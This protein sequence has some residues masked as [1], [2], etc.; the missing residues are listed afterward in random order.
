MVLQEELLVELQ[1][2]CWHQQLGVQRVG[3]QMDYW[4][5]LVVELGHQKTVGLLLGAFL[6]QKH[7]DHIRQNC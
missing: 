2:D 4:H 3:L 7:W 6:G 5:Q 1:K